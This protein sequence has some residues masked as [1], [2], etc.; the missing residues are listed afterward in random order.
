LK[1]VVT[2]GV[3]KIGQWVVK[4][5]ID[6]SEGKTPHE[7]VV[8]D[9]VIGP[10]S[11]PFQTGPI[12]YLLGDVLDLGQVMSALAGVDAVIHMA[13]LPAPRY[14]TDDVTFRNNVLGTFNVHEAAWRLGIRRVVSTSSTGILGWVYRERDFLPAYLPIDE[15]HPI[16]PQ[17]S[18]GL[19]KKVS[20]DIARSYADR[21]DMETIALRPSGVMTPEQLVELRAAGGRNPARFGLGDYVDLR[22]LARAYRLAVERPL[23]GWNVAFVVADDSNFPIPLSEVLPKLMPGL[24]ELA[25]DLTGTMSGISNVRAKKLLGW[26]PEHSW[27]VAK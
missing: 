23:S 17:D 21:S 16:N 7:V 6:G 22:D 11:G 12:R 2:G 3:G 1:I 24:G 26:Q 25:K 20:E 10:A 19:S 8:F 5:L 14:T 18:Y 13:A 27:R 9:R 15:D 4:E